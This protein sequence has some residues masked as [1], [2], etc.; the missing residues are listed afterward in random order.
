M[1]KCRSSSSNFKCLKTI[2]GSYI[3]YPFRS[4]FLN[5]GK[6]D[7]GSSSCRDK[8]WEDK[9]KINFNKGEGLNAFNFRKQRRHCTLLAATTLAHTASIAALSS[10]LLCFFSFA[11]FDFL[12]RD[13][14]CQTSNLNELCH[15]NKHPYNF[16]CFFFYNKSPQL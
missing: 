8:R 1:S 11:L 4:Y 16:P 7:R 12:C 5:T 9:N 15:L 13:K 14:D 10:S 2:W 3:T 6:A